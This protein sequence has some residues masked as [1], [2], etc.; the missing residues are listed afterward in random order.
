MVPSLSD[1]T[2]RR[3]RLFD[4]PSYELFVNLVGPKKRF[5]TSLAR[6]ANQTKVASGRF[7]LT[8]F[9]NHSHCLG[10]CIGLL[11]SLSGQNGQFQLP[12]MVSKVGLPNRD[13]KRHRMSNDGKKL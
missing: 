12:R 5:V 6:Y 9:A 10:S 2:A 1:K 7:E 3:P 8:A 13:A 4:G 11:L